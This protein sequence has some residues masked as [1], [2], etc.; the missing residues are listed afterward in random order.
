MAE[1]LRMQ[2]GR[3]SLH[4][5]SLIVPAHNE[6]AY[7]PRLLESVAKARHAYRGGKESI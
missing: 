7:L 1:Q 4:W 6:E 3:P 2:E 5:L